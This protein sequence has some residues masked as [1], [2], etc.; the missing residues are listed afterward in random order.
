MLENHVGRFYVV[1]EIKCVALLNLN[2]KT[3]HIYWKLA[4]FKSFKR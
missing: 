2:I 4:T 1:C 3:V